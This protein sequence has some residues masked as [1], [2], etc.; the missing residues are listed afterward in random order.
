VECD[1]CQRSNFS[2]WKLGE[3]YDGIDI[4]H[5]PPEFISDFFKESWSG[6]FYF[7]CRKCHVELHREIKQIL[8]KNSKA[9]K[10]VNSEYWLMQKMTPSQIKKAKE[11]IYIFTRKWIKKDDTTTT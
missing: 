5:N 11:E 3:T 6:E 1:K 7:L 8:H 9:I 4:H 2:S 10:F